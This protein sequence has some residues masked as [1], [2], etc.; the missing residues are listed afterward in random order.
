LTHSDENI[1]LAE[2][3]GVTL[4]E[5]GFA[6]CAECGQY[7]GGRCFVSVEASRATVRDFIGKLEWEQFS[8]PDDADERERL[9]EIRELT[10][11]QLADDTYDVGRSYIGAKSRGSILPL[12]DDNRYNSSWNERSERERVIETGIE[13]FL[14]QL[15]GEQRVVVRMRYGAQ[16]SQQE[17]AE[18]LHI[19]QQAVNARLRTIH[20]ALRRVLVFAYVSDE[21]GEGP[22]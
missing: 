20:E 7:H 5:V 22:R 15:T 19:T 14:D 17:I 9:M 13:P 2:R 1:A 21:T 6:H 4:P 11:Q 16:M 8:H 12:H 18:A 10:I 3:L